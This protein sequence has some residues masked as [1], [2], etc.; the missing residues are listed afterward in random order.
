MHISQTHTHTVL[1]H[2]NTKLK[3]MKAWKSCLF[4]PSSSLREGVIQS[5]TAHQFRQY[6]HKMLF[7]VQLYC[8]SHMAPEPTALRQKCVPDWHE[9]ASITL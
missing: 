1:T 2:L 4:T 5:V 6:C 7:L 8:H 9:R 3:D